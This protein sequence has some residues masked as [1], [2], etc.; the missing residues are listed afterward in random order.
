MAD[1]VDKFKESNIHKINIL[2]E[3]RYDVTEAKT[4]EQWREN[5]WSWKKN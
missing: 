1:I 4:K 5:F 2:E 3:N